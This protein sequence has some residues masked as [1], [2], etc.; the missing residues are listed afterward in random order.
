MKKTVES[1]NIF[2]PEVSYS[3]N[4]GNFMATYKGCL[5]EG[6]GR[7]EEVVGVSQVRTHRD[8]RGR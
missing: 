8:K 5:S 3:C 1:D 6:G 7:L 2:K 4:I